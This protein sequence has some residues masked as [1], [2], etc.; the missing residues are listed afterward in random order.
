VTPQRLANTDVVLLQDIKD[1]VIY[2]IS[3]TIGTEFLEYI[4]LSI[5]DRFLRALI[6][7]MQH[8]LTIWGELQLKRE[9]VSKSLPNPLAG[10]ARVVR[11]QELRALRC[12]LAREY[13]DLLLACQPEA[14]KYHHTGAGEISLN[15][16]LG[17][18]DLRIFEGL[19]QFAHR[20]VWIALERKHKDLI[21]KS[22]ETSPLAFI[23]ILLQC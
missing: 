17:E 1:L 23:M 8:Y 12:L 10:G 11:S 14:K 5:V 6:L 19:I 20:V 13:A 15:K 18:K 9:T 4:H 7:Y 16:S 2:Q 3:A 21:G 22:I